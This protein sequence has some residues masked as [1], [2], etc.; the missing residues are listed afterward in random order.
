[1]YVA[2][3]VPGNLVRAQRGVIMT[4]PDGERRFCKSNEVAVVLAAFPNMPLRPVWFVFEDGQIAIDSDLLW[5]G[6][7]GREVAAALQCL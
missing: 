1:M 3:L 4:K 6:P 7:Q 2:T 5:A